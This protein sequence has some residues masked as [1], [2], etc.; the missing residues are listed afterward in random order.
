V[1]RDLRRV[2]EQA[3]LRPLIRAAAREVLEAAPN[4]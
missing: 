2:A 3:A 1:P 4:R